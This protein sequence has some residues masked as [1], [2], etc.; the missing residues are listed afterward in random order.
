M[1]PSEWTKP[2]DS[3]VHA[4]N[5]PSTNCV[6]SLVDDNEIESITSILCN[7]GGILTYF[8][9]S[10]HVAGVQSSSVSQGWGTSNASVIESLTSTLPIISYLEVLEIL[11]QCR[12]LPFSPNEY[13]GREFI[14]E[15]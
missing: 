11:R 13:A 8:S 3:L 2:I 10:M 14:K 6:T 4:L 12:Y 5:H 1:T 9:N 15:I 7:V